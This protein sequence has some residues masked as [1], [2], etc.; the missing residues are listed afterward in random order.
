MCTVRSIWRGHIG[1]LPTLNWVLSIFSLPLHHSRD[2]L[3][4]AL[5]VLQLGG[6]W[7]EA[8]SHLYAC[9]HQCWDTILCHHLFEMLLFSRHPK[10][11]RIHP[12]SA[13]Y[14][15]IALLSS[16]SK[17]MEWSI[18]LTWESFFTTSGLQFGF[19]WGFSTT[20]CTGVLK[21]V[22]N[23]YLNE[24][25]KVF[26]CLIDASKALVWLT[27]VF[28]LI[29]CW[30]GVRTPKPVVRLLLPWYKSQQLCICWMGRSSDYFQVTTQA[31]AQAAIAK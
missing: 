28:S 29:S 22:I 14:C 18:L 23:H 16:L 30:K 2:K 26:A 25:S 8:R 20:L 15:R 12:L 27:T 13:N 19:K 5:S 9:S 11:P 3:F 21:A 7:K 6:A 31:I 17:A 24:G 1:N 10:G 4:Q